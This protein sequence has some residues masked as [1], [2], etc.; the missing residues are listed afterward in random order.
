MKVDISEDEMFPFYNVDRDG[1]GHHDIEVRMTEKKYTWCIWV[2]EEFD[3]V[4]KYLEKRYD[5]ATRDN[6]EQA[7]KEGKQNVTPF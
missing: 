7:F 1:D 5:K 3:K 4:Q 6:I 2:L